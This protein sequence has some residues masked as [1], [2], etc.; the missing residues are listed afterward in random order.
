MK[1]TSKKISGVSKKL[2]RMGKDRFINKISHVS[3]VSHIVKTVAEINLSKENR[4]NSEIF[5]FT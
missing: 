4:I 3:Y 5:F 1:N 2:T